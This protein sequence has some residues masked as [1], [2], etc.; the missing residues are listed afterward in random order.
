MGGFRTE[1]LGKFIVECIREKVGLG[2]DFVVCRY[3]YAD[4]SVV[5]EYAHPESDILGR[6]GSVQIR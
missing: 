5:A 4:A 3:T 6:R 2:D 1:N